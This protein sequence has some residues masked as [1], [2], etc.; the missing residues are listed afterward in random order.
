MEIKS[1]T[2]R[3]FA[4]KYSS[5]EQGRSSPAK[6]KKSLFRES[7]LLKDR[8]KRNVR[9]KKAEH[10][11]VDIQKK[12]STDDNKFSSPVSEAPFRLSGMTGKL[13]RVLVPQIPDNPQCREAARS[14]ENSDVQ[15]IPEIP[16]AQEEP[17]IKTD[18]EIQT[19]MAS[20]KTSSLFESK[21]QHWKVWTA[22]A[23]FLLLLIA[24]LFLL[25]SLWR[26]GISGTAANG[27]NSSTVEN[28][29]PSD[30]MNAI[31]QETLQRLQEEEQ[32]VKKD[33]YPEVNSLVDSYFA[34]LA[35]GDK[36]AYQETV[37]VYSEEELEALEASAEPIEEYQD[38]SCYT[39][40]GL[41]EGAYFVF[42]SYQLKFL[43]AEMP[44]PGLT[45][46][47]VYPDTE[48]NLKVFNGTADVALLE[49]ADA[50]SSDP[51]IA[52]LTEQV[53]AAYEKAL[54][55]DEDL[56][57]LIGGYEKTDS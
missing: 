50:A 54:E 7:E 18:S 25:A 32:K 21:K 56:A 3:K 37:D 11:L 47:Y 19:N 33:A 38:I 36:E 45:T 42:V 1:A 28:G 23:L 6:P 27:M 51:E 46:L 4:N 17:K 44:A 40:P 15:E 24:L 2:Y 20:G 39:K 29:I 55:A 57:D 53:N 22:A 34:A 9:E 43:E 13:P 30:Y 8:E 12:E 35:S 10:N 48:G 16:E 14:Q 41:S 5:S 26:T 52:A 31:T 49:A